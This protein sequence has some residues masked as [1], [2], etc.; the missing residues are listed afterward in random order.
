[1]SSFLAR[2]IAVALLLLLGV[3][4]IGFSILNLAPGGPLSMLAATGDLSQ[5]DLKRLGTQMGLD[6]PLPVQYLRWLGHLLEGDWGRSYRDHLPVLEIIASRLGATFLLMLTSTGIAV[7]L[8][9]WIGVMSG[10][11][12]GGRF[13]TATS[14][15][16][17][18][19]VSIPTFWLGLV[20]IYLFSVKLGWLPPGNRETPGDGS[21]VDLL[22]HLLMPALV[23]AM[24]HVAVWSRYMRASVIDAFSQDYIRTAR[25]KGL[26]QAQVLWRHVLPN[27]LLPMISIAGMHI[28]AQLGGALVTETVFTWPGMGRLFMDSLNY[29]D[30]PVVLGVLMLTA[31]LTLLGSLLADL[32]Y[33]IA[34]PRVRPN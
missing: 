33:A 2:R 11:R 31:V 29:R 3:S 9:T 14:V 25:A 18:T 28:P 13:D 1:M 21:F 22:S 24:V 32:G 23:L 10:V 30:Y 26:S 6:D 19:L 34:D 8:G 16:F 7:V 17:V 5:E 4:V 20:A 15:L 27:S 12:R